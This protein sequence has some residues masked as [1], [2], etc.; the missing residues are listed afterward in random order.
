MFAMV[1]EGL[2]HHNPTL[3]RWCLCAIVEQLQVTGAITKL[4]NRG[5][6]PHPFPNPKVPKKS[7]SLIFQYSWYHFWGIC[8]ETLGLGRGG[9]L[10]QGY[11]LEQSRNT[12]LPSQSLSVYQIWVRAI[13]V[14]LH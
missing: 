6:T 3:G 4:P 13:N 12:I 14:D 5:S 7:K 8:F 10:T 2:A 9:G 11:I 1:C